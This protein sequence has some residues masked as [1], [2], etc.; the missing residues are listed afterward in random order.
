[1]IKRIIYLP[2]LI[3]VIATGC[4]VGKSAFNPD[5]Q[6]PKEKLQKDYLVFREILEESH[7]SLYWYTPKD[8]MDY[9]FDM[10]YNRINDSM[11][12]PAF[13]TL[14]SYVISKVNCG[15]TSIKNS[16]NFSRYLDTAKL[17]AFPLGIK[18]W[19]DTAVIYSNL[20]RRDSTLKRGT[21][22]T[23]INKLPMTAIRDSLFQFMVTDGYSINHKY[24][25]LSNLGNFG[26][27]YK[28]VFGY[29]N[30]L[31]VNYLDSTGTE[32][33]TTIAPFDYRRDSAFRR[34]TSNL[35][36]PSRK[37]RRQNRLT[38]ARSIQI[39]TTGSTAFMSLNTFTDGNRLRTFFRQSFRELH[40]RN[41]QHLI[42]DVRGNGGGN[43]SLSNKL[44][45]YLAAKPFKLADSLYAVKKR[46]RFEQN[47]QNS[48]VSAMFMTFM[49]SRRMDGNYHFRYF[50]RHV[51]KP[52]K[53]HHYNGDVYMLTGGNSFSATTLVVHALKGQQNVK[54]IGEETGG[55]AYGNSAWFIPD[56]TL[57]MTGVRFR[58][59]KFHMVMDKNLPKNGRGIVPDIEV[60]PTVKAIREGFDIKL[61]YTKKLIYAMK[62]K[63]TSAAGFSSK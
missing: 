56:V 35:Y 34:F 45:R 13:R 33:I 52:K 60:V 3:F 62:Q 12:E 8:S 5:Y 9:Y 22:I 2:L 14:L 38:G 51:F 30:K 41:I 42:I 40:K 48:F 21:V 26:G 25:S 53:K 19:S 23:A 63:A 20:N 58:L 39:D 28:S 31:E 37:E 44:T 7:P 47:I 11:S 59:P 16:K 57:P 61:E 10:G 49:T 4:S 29:S 18:F 55:G 54:I 27:L 6:Y 46:S 17:T 32:R 15:H 1:M 36:K 24:Q 43:V 50:E